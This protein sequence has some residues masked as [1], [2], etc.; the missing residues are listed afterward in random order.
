MIEYENSITR[1]RKWMLYLLAIFVLGAGFT[2]YVRIFLGLILG[3]LISFY[4]LWVLQR[5]IRLFGKAAAE[6]GSVYG[7]GTFTRLA[8]A[9]LAV[10]IAM[11]FEEYFHFL[12]VVAGLGTSYVIIMIDFAIQFLTKKNS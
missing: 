12:A 2:P 7:I 3:S 9:G 11:Q 8:A 5:K 4:N 1:Q 10:I 6:G